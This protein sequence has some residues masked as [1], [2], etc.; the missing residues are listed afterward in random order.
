MV[1]RARVALVKYQADG[2]SVT[3]MFNA[4]SAV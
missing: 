1:A 2:F 3:G 4:K